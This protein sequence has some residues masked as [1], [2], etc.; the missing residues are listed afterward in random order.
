MGISLYMSITVTI[1]YGD[2][3]IWGLLDM[4]IIYQIALPIYIYIWLYKYDMNIGIPSY[5]HPL[6]VFYFGICY[7]YVINDG[8]DSTN[9]GILHEHTN[10][11]I[12]IGHT[13]LMRCPICCFMFKR[14]VATI[15][16][17]GLFSCIWKKSIVSHQILLQLILGNVLDFPLWRFKKFHSNCH[18]RSESLTLR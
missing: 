12:S 4:G 17:V 18:V 3:Y 7:G 11:E 9:I 16:Y 13:T 14:R 1:I 6:T 15:A 5:F 8:W 2:H 10:V